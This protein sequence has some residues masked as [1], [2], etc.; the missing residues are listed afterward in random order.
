MQFYT[1]L[2]SFLL[3]HVCPF[4]F[5]ALIYCILVAFYIFFIFCTIIV[6][7]KPYIRE[8]ETQEVT[9]RCRLSVL[10]IA[11]SHMSPNAGGWVLGLCQ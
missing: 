8:F 3:A 10:T 9:K 7:F 5:I 2:L 4:L 1:R 11:P 6:V